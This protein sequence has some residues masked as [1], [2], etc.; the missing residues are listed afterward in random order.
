[1]H[2]AEQGDF[3]DFVKGDAYPTSIVVIMADV[4][5]IPFVVVERC[6]DEKA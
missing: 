2:K 6:K 4:Y 3:S 5:S 1:M